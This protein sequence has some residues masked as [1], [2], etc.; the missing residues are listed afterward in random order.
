MAGGYSLDN[1]ASDVGQMVGGAGLV[2]AAWMFLRW[3]LTLAGGRQDARIAKLESD[4]K[5][6]STKVV[7]LGEALALLLAEHRMKV[8]G[9][10]DAILRAERVLKKAFPLTPEVPDSLIDLAARLDAKD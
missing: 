9:S 3:L 8:T 10:S 4:L 7:M 6:N 2:G 1:A 5:E